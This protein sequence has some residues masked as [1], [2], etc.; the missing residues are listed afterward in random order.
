MKKIAASKAAAVSSNFIAIPSLWYGSAPG[1]RPYSIVLD[2]GIAG[3]TQ[4]AM[5]A[6]Q[7]CRVV[8]P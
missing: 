6:L 2:F 5:Q 3:Q 4:L 8:I 7:P 1:R